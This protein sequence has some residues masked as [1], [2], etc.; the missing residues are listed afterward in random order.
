MSELH[1]TARRAGDSGEEGKATPSGVY[2]AAWECRSQVIDSDTVQLD[3]KNIIEM[4][5]MHPPKTN[6]YLQEE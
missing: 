3:P 4:T 2:V 6:N 5:T 1:C